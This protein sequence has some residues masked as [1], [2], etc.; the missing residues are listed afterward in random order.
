MRGGYDIEQVFIGDITELNMWDKILEDQ[1]I[2][3]MAHCTYFPK[4]NVV[5]WDKTKFKINKAQ[6]KMLEERKAVCKKSKQLFMFA[7]RMSLVEARALCF[8]HGGR[9]FTPNSEDENKDLLALANTY[10]DRCENK[11]TNIIVWLGL[12]KK[13]GTWYENSDGDTIS[14]AQTN[15]TNW[16]SQEGSVIKRPFHN[17]LLRNGCYKMA[18]LQKCPWAHNGQ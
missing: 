15:F 10:K 14:P 9:I 8:I 2:E 7:S 18:M 17:G 12:E 6:V 3:K 11:D 13:K 1:D 5:T 4:G 16:K